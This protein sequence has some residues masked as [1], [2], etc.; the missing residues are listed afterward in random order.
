MY[1]YIY[2]LIY[3]GCVYINHDFSIIFLLQ[4]ICGTNPVFTILYA[5]T[6][7]KY[8][9]VCRYSCIHIYTY[10]CTVYIAYIIA[11]TREC[12]ISKVE[13]AER[14]VCWPLLF[15]MMAHTYICICIFIYIDVFIYLNMYMYV[16]AL[17]TLVD[18]FI[19]MN[20]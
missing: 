9:H 2:I 19:Y 1:I 12:K 14:I 8:I 16:C 17:Y 10:I 7:C 20:I 15:M 3:K 5:Q 4:F 11:G 6:L 13:S 18:M